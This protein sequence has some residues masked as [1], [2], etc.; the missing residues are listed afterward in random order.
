MWS[1]ENKATQE[2]L[3]SNTSLSIIEYREQC[4]LYMDAHK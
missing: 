2:Y 3:Q 1:E 4:A